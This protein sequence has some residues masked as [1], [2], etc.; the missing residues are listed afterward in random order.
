[1]VDAQ[2]RVIW[3]KPQ[4]GRR[5]HATRGFTLHDGFHLNDYKLDLL[6]SRIAGHVQQLQLDDLPRP[7]RRVQIGQRRICLSQDE[8]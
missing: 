7:P 1:M 8:I 2:M 4:R 6:S 3:S 5:A